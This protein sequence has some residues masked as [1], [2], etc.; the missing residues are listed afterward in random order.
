MVAADRWPGHLVVVVPR[1]FED[2]NALLDLTIVQAHKPEWDI[3]LQ[4]LCLRVND[5]FVCGRTPHNGK[6]NGSLV[7]Y[8][9][10][11]DDHSYNDDGNWM[12]IKGLDEAASNVVR[13]LT[14]R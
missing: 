10:Y 4:P 8:D 7:I 9:A 1:V 13:R 11:P 2:R 12:A 5:D 3:S 6:V 14:S